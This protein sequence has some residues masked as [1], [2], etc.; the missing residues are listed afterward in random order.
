[1]WVNR[2]IGLR[3][4][5]LRI[6]GAQKRAERLEEKQRRFLAALLVLVAVLLLAGWRT[7]QA[8]QE[9]FKTHGL[10][11]V[12]SGGVVRLILGA[13]VPNP[14]EEGKT[15]ERRS[16]GTGIVFNDAAGN[17][18]GGM[19]MLD[20]GSMNLCFDDAKAERNCLF[21]VAKLGNGIALNDAR[22]ETSA[23]LY[24][25]TNGAPHFLLKDEQGH[26]LVSL[27]EAPKGPAV[28]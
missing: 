11:M 24:L 18:Q 20:D 25:D 9:N 6:Y 16:P 28:K 13:P 21:F 2:T 22:A 27:P 8:P 12:D 15:Y 5:H 7:V 3:R 19:G 10:S 1:M 17:E 14:V 23:T 4:G 26:S